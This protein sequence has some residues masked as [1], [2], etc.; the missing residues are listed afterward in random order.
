M[1]TGPETLNLE[2]ALAEA[3]TR[4]FGGTIVEF[5]ETR[6]EKFVWIREW[7]AERQSVVFNL[8]TGFECQE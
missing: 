4:H 5:Y 2:R 3:R 6:I 7:G 1:L 8:T